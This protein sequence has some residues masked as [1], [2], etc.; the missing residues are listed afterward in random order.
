MKS[1]TLAIITLLFPMVLLV[2]I[3]TIP[4][5]S[6]YADDIVTEEA[7]SQSARWFW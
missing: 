2:G 5:V 3:F 1:K 7:A 4:F 6:D